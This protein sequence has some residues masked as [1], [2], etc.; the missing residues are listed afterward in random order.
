MAGLSA[1]A[2]HPC[3][4]G[5]PL[6][7]ANDGDGFTRARLLQRR[8]T[9]THRLQ[10]ALALIQARSQDG[11]ADEEEEEEEGTP[12]ELVVEQSA[13]ESTSE[14]EAAVGGGS[15]EA[16]EAPVTVDQERS[17]S[18]E[19]RSSLVKRSW[20]LAFRAAKMQMGATA[21]AATP[22]SEASKG[23][24]L[25]S[26]AAPALTDHEELPAAP[27]ADAP[28]APKRSGWK[29]L[30]VGFALAAELSSCAAKSTTGVD[31]SLKDANEHFL[32]VFNQFLH[33]QVVAC[34]TEVR[35]CSCVAPVV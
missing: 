23:V 28:S 9:A 10:A 5:A 4:M 17:Q 1:C 16:V 34:R 30:S 2:V 26:S 13:G 18:E 19:E 12:H 31:T 15:V 21:T 35:A 29:A 33:E 25:S 20:R 8:D 11:Q 3:S 27:L 6:P 24:A 7:A 32:T 14:M 22:T